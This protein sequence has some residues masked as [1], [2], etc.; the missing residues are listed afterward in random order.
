MRLTSGTIRLLL[1]LCGVAATAAQAQQGTIAGTVTDRVGGAPLA[2]ARI[3][4]V[5]TNRSAVTSQEGRYTLAGL[6][7]GSYTV[8]ASLIGYGAASNTASVTAGGIETLDFVIKAVAVSLDAI[9]VTTTGEERTRVM[10][11]VVTSINAAQ[12]TAE[13]DR[14]SVV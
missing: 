6:K 11:N 2:G 3:T 7:V 10:G 9:V 12:R 4:V 13:A 14:K 8:Q 5:G 1:G